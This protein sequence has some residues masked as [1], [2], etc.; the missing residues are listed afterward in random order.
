M[1]TLNTLFIMK[2]PTDNSYMA[3]FSGIDGSG[4]QCIEE[5][6]INIDEPNKEYAKF[7]AMSIWGITEDNLKVTYCSRS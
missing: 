1:K 2:H 4:K 3:Q 6:A 7:A 5:D